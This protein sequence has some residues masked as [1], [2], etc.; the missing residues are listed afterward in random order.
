MALELASSNNIDV[1]AAIDPVRKALN[2]AVGELFASVD[3]V[4]CA[5]NP[6]N[7]RGRRGTVRRGR[8]GWRT[9]QRIGRAP[10]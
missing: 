9:G 2:A 6:D 4:L 3:L 1:A 8:G 5:M 7:P 10:R